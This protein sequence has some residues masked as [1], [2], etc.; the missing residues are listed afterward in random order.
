MAVQQL[1]YRTAVPVNFQRH[2]D[3]SVKAGSDFRFAREVNSVPITAVEFAQ[4][5]AEYPI[6]FAGEGEAI[7]PAVILGTRD[8]ENLF[9]AEDGSWTGRYT[10]AFVR[11]YPFVFSIDEKK[12]RFTLLIDEEFAGANRTGRGE[13]LFD[14]DGDQTQYLKGVLQFLQ[15]YQARFTRTQTFCRKLVEYDLLQP[16]QAQFDLGAGERRTL[17]GFHILNR[18]KLK[19]LAPEVLHDMCQTDEL[20]CI[21][22]HLA[23]LRHFR[24]MIDR[25]MPAP[26]PLEDESSN[27]LDD[28]VKEPEQATID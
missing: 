7:F 21:Y 5:A 13:R 27:D 18:D 24:D 23:S 17:A 16:V 19:E 8:G 20:E 14:A 3:L 2:H 11:R 4:A 15:D 9:V 28:S 26:A 12:E 1:F 25:N 6:V 22:A 10:P